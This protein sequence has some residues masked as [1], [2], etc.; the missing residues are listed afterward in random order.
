MVLGPRSTQLADLVTTLHGRDQISAELD[1]LL[2]RAR[3]AR[4]GAL[5]VLGGT[6]TGKSA[7]LRSIGAAAPDFQLL[8]TSGVPAESVVPMSGLHRLLQP[9]AG[10]LP[11]LPTPHDGVIAE[12]IGAAVAR[13]AA[14]FALCTSVH[15][16]FVELGRRGPV[17]ACVDD[18]HWLDEVSLVALAFLARRADTERVAVVFAGDESL[19]TGPAA[20][21][22][23]GLRRLWLT[24]LDDEASLRVLADRTRAR[25]A[26]DTAADLVELASGNPLA[27]VE[28]ADAL[29]T[30][31]LAGRSPTPVSV[32]ADSSLRRT[33][34]LRFGQL[35]VLAQRV[36]LMAVVDEQL[37]VTNVLGT[38][39]DLAAVDEAAGSGLVVIDNDANNAVLV[40]TQ[41]TRSILYSQAAPDQLHAAHRTLATRLDPDWDRLRVTW[42]RAATEQTSG[43]QLA[44]EL[45]DSA[46]AAHETGNYAEASTAFE[47]AASLVE[48][49]G[50]R[51]QW[52]VEAACGSWLVGG[53]RRTRALLRQAAPLT[54][55]VGA[56]GPMNM[57]HGI[58]E[59]GDGSPAEASRKLRIA[60]EQLLD[61]DRARALTALA[62]AAEACG[63][64]GD[65]DGL[66]DVAGRAAEL[67]R[68]DEQRATELMFDHLAGTA[69]TFSGQPTDAVGPLRA[70]V[71]LAA[72]VDDPL[73]T[74][75]ASQAAYSLGDVSHSLELAGQAVTGARARSL[76]T[77]VPWALIDVALAA[78]LL[79]RHSTAESAA[80]EGLREAKAIGQHNTAMTHLNLLALLAAYRGDRETVVR[81]MDVSAVWVIDHGLALPGTIGWW[82]LAC[83]DLAEEQ[84]AEA[85]DQLRLMTATTGHVHRGMQV[86]AAPHVVEAAVGCQQPGL[87]AVALAIFDR[88]AGNSNCGPRQALSHR[89]H[90]L[91]AE[92]PADADE[93]FREAIRLHRSS[94][95][96]L[97][98]A[99]TELFYGHRLRHGRKPTAARELLRDAVKIFHDYHAETWARRATAE[100]RAAGESV[101]FAELGTTGQLTTQQLEIS[102]LVA[103][104]ATN[105]EIAAQ[106]FVSTRTVDHHLRNI[107]AKLGVRSRLELAAQ[108]R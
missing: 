62:L 59:F 52:L 35:S 12:L 92:R 46:T 94:N 23:S 107:F 97:E 9:L 68:P 13:P 55:L 31:Q 101:P 7:V 87:G 96:A 3:G 29:T 40:P 24:A 72:T 21:Q 8:H 43:Q 58:V 36:V 51:V 60:A 54:E 105:R 56:R 91:L 14:D 108:F 19:A 38:D 102:R 81:R 57:V 67:R 98:L 71:R 33:V 16:L 18:A 15:R 10:R 25:L 49:P 106:L 44:R 48:Q 28:L 64:T 103:E 99:K 77:L 50:T 11:E 39:I 4:G 95:T 83:L 26:A 5:A 88:W 34:S 90:A 65:Y 70:V 27:L 47:R 84:P 74:I 82:A 45:G 37:A 85:L 78:L 73:A 1:G 22:L 86:V 75:L 89:C 80:L 32:P 100:L 66:A 41:L 17:L 30:A 76:T 20:D 79:D 93:H 69:A 53:G 42:H 6:G 2:D 104:G 61:T 63:S